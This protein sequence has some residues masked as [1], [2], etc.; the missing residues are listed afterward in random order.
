MSAPRLR[1]VSSLSAS[2]LL[3]GAAFAQPSLT[4]IGTPLQ[5]VDASADGT[6]LVGTG[7]IQTFTGTDPAYHWSVSGGLVQL[8]ISGAGGNIN[9]A[10]V[11][12]ISANGQAIIGWLYFA[13]TYSMYFPVTWNIAAP[14]SL[15]TYLTPANATGRGVGSD[16]SADGTRIA[17]LYDLTTPA[18][19]T[20]F[21]RN[22][23]GGT[24]TALDTPSAQRRFSTVVLSRSAQHAC[25]SFSP[26]IVP[27]ARG[28]VWSAVDGFTDI[29]TPAGFASFNPQAISDDGLILAGS[30]RRQNPPSQSAFGPFIWTQAAGF[31]ALPLPSQAV[32]GIAS[33]VTADGVLVSGHVGDTITFLNA[34]AVVWTPQ[35]VFTV[36]QL[37]T[38]AGVD[39]STV[40]LRTADVIAADGSFIIGSGSRRVGASFVLD[41]YILREV[42]IPRCDSIDFNRNGVFPEDQDVIDFFSVLGGGACSTGNACGDI[43][44]NNNAVFLEDQDVIDFLTTLAGGKC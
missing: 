43:D 7:G 21:I 24:W 40:N 14:G 2:T 38:D 15:G 39:V 26:G 31:R 20:A 16:I 13:P 41:T 27:N 5:V 22:A 42:F 35:G 29:G 4:W 6:A 36:A 11:G 8:P 32:T 34:H 33:D 9:R 44:I 18:T 23:A 30:A 19:T 37:A 17:A 28:Y 1:R 3:A 25:G 12:G 10:G